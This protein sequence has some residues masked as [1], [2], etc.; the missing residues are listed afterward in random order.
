M[1]VCPQCQF[2]NP[3]DHKFCQKCGVSLTEVICPGCDATVPSDTEQ[4]PHCDTT[5]GTFWWAVQLPNSS[6]LSSQTTEPPSQPAETQLTDTAATTASYLDPQQRYKLLSPLSPS[7]VSGLEARVLDCQPYQPTLLELLQEKL[8]E[9]VKESESKERFAQPGDVMS[10]T[11]EPSLIKDRTVP[12]VARIYLALQPQLHPALPR[13]HDTWEQDGQV[14]LLLEDRS[15]LMLLSDAW[16]SDDVLPLQILHWLY[17]MTEVWQLLEPHHCCQSLLDINNLRIDEDQL[18]CLQRLHFDTPGHPLQL[19]DLGRLWQMLFQMSQ[20]TQL[21]SLVRLCHDLESGGVTDIE[22][23]QSQFE[24]IANE[25]QPDVV[26]SPVPQP[27]PPFTFPDDDDRTIELTTSGVRATAYPAADMSVSTSSTRFELGSLEDDSTSEGDDI[28]TVVLPMKLINLEDAGRTDVGK[29]R[30]HNEDCFS[31]HVE[32]KKVESPSGRTV[33]AKGLYILCDGMGGH[34]GGEVASAMAVESLKKYFEVNWQDQL[35]SEASIRE[36]IQL[37]NKT[38]YD[39]NQQNDRSGSGRMGTTLVLLLLHDTHAAIAHV[40]DS[41]LYRFSRRRG[42]EQIT[43]DHEVGQREIQRGVEP[44]IAYA[45]PDAYQL[46]QAL[47]PRDEHFVNPDVQF[48]ELNEDLLL[49]LC[50]D[51]LTDNDLLETHWRTHIEPLVS[52]QANLEQGVSQLID[53]ANQYNGHDNITAV[54]IKA[55]VRPNLDQ[56][57]R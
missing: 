50:S 40:G 28:P 41:R 45:R 53:L 54:A 29:Q 42:L 13:L 4:C 8:P 21:G 48:M 32:L 37:T 49:L 9:L 10:S 46:T 1:L 23:L 55:K 26:H 6:A 19:K 18:L 14:T 22:M 35:P 51:G 5:T 38:I 17:Q 57:K 12:A 27:P 43:V 25:L 7:S 39:L 36:A 11:E 3:N 24:A 20:R 31:I 34:A 33:Q 16:R 15:D 44:A 2:E 56:L 52:S 30:D 47:G